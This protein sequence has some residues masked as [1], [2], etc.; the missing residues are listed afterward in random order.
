MRDLPEIS[1]SE[2][3]DTIA[4]CNM[5]CI[6]ISYELEAMEIPSPLHLDCLVIYSDVMSVYSDELNECVGMN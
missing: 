1:L 6:K 4:S 2:I 3:M 5:T